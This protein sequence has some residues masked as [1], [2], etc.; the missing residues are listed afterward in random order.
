MDK[1]LRLASNLAGKVAKQ[2]GETET[3]WTR[4][5]LKIA[6]CVCI[7]VT[8][9]LA[10]TLGLP[11]KVRANDD[12]VRIFT[13]DVAF[14]N[15]YFQNNVDP[16]ESG[17]DFTRGDTFIQDGSIYPGHTILDGQSGFDPDTP[18]AIGTYRARGTWTTDLPTYLRAL[19]KDKRKD[20]DPA[21]AFATELFSFRNERK[22]IL[23]DGPMPNANFAASRVV[24]GGTG[25]FRDI[26]GEVDEENIGDNKLG[27]CNL[28]VTFKI[29]RVSD[30]RWR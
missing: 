14:R 30:A 18:G 15:P 4:K 23:T 1:A 3:S 16:A 10:F 29:R 13:V 5:A 6:A 20:V 2:F 19:D 24:L 25:S 28:R 12:E 11:S 7:A 8:A 22:T 26:I 17:S 27:Y 9:V 21:M